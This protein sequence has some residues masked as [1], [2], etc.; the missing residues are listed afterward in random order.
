MKNNFFVLIFSILFLSNVYA[1]E[2]VTLQLKWFHQFQFAGYY[3]AK[4]KGFYEELGLDVEIKE[5]DLK[6]NNIDEVIKG[7]A[8]YGI[9]DSILILYK[10]KNEPIVIISPIFQHSPSV[11]ISLKKKNIDS[12]YEL[13]NKKILFYPNDTD[14]FSLLAMLKKF[15][16]KANLDRKR[17]KNDYVKLMNEEVDLM[18]AYIA[19]EPFLFKEKGYDVNIINPSHY[20]FD[21]Y[22]DIIF[23]NKYEAENYPDRVKKFREATLKGWEYALD[24]KEEIIQLIHEKYAKNKSIEHLRY[25]ANAIETLIARKVIPLGYLDKGRI[26]YISELYK[27]YGLTDSKINLNEFIF[28]DF[29]DKGSKISLSDEEREY[30]EKNPVL[31]VHSMDS[32]PP[33]NFRIN[34]QPT[35]FVVDYLQLVSKILN[36]KIEYI[37]D[38]TWKESLEMLKE[39]QLDV[40]PNIA[41]NEERKKFINFTDFSLFNYQVA[42]GTKKDLNI[43]KIQDLNGKTISVLENSFLHNILKKEYPLINLYPTKTIKEAI[44]AVSSGKSDAVIDNLTTL[45]YYISV[46]WLSNLKTTSLVNDGILPSSVPLYLG[47]RKDNVILKSILE[48]VNTTISEKE[49]IELVDIWF[50]KSFQEEIKL[51][52]QEHSYL[53]DKRKLNYCINKNLMPIEKIENDK[54]VGI[55][56]DY[57][58]IFKEKLGVNFNAIAI[59]NLEDT[60]DKLQ[61]FDCDFA[62]FVLKN[63][64]N[65]NKLNFTDSYISFPL[66]LTT[67]LEEPFINTLQSLDGKKIAIMKGSGYRELIINENSDIQFVEVSTVTE[68]LQKVENREV[69][70][71][72]E[73]LPVVGYELQKGFSSSLKISKELFSDLNFY[74]TTSKSDFILIDILDKLLKTIPLETKEIILSKWTSINYEKSVDYQKIIFVSLF[75]IFIIVIIYLKNRQINKINSQMKKY[76]KIV[77][78]NVLTS[79]TDKKG[80]IIYVS[81]AF[82]EISGYTKE[83]LIGQNHR[84]IRHEDMPKKLFQELWNTITNGKVWQGEIKNKKKN[85]EF[86]WVKATISPVFDDNKNIVGYTA[87]REDITDKKR[88]EQISITDELTTLYNRRFFN[89]IFEREVNRAKRDEHPFALIIFDVDFFKLYNDSYGHQAGDL[90]LQKIGKKIKEL[91][92]RSSDFA[93]RIGGEEFAIIFTPHFK[94]NAVE[95]AN[96]IN[97]EIEDLK[98]EH[99][100]N[101]AS[102]YITASVGIYTQIGNELDTTKEIYYFTDL[103]LYEAK[104]NGR[105][106]YVVFNKNLVK[107]KE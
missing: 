70:G 27:Y 2:K 35:G 64:S 102:P 23:T 56:S 45:E 25:E 93:F 43:L 42:I 51:T 97:K 61:N 81:K 57:I 86:Y 49:I 50:N 60:F 88:V 68:G 78:E 89:E 58:Q 53:S 107:E 41:I 20:G 66:V 3:T 98:I 62:P 8:Q 21:I 83:E 38:K 103:A 36:I 94:E 63:K 76:I 26:Q 74:M 4:E 46:N 79:S 92:K 99:K 7:N 13:N 5:R 104:K 90:V 40:L 12:V 84:I 10:I 106:G 75:F 77:D 59:D 47:L 100:H 14:G 96:L 85:G 44:E 24:N 72:V 32:F 9:A 11:F 91:C 73:I 17:E 39:G 87:I 34:E 1:N 95:F 55:N 19:N 16:I 52:K 22:G 54:V 33:F 65:M 15:D 6:Y 71:F 18:P 105:N 101:K 67:R 29:I 28:D 48:K 82:C 80:R 30:L 69:F 37:K 31:K